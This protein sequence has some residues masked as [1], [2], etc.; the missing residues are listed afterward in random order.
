MSFRKNLFKNIIVLGG[1][2][3]TTQIISF[4]ATIVLSRLL[5][6]EEYGF[7]ALITVFTGFVKT[8]SDA[9]LS[10]LVIRSDYGKLFQRVL[11]YLSFIVGLILF[12]LVVLLAY[13][14]SLFYKD[15]ALILP[16]IIMSLNFILRSLTTVPFGVLSKEL[17]FN[18]L[19]S[20]ELI[21]ATIEVLFMI[22]LAYLGFSYWA[23]IIPSVIGSIARI[24]MYYA[25][26]GLKLK[27]YSRKYLVVGFRK[28]KS[29]IG[30]LS[31]FTFFN[32]WARNSDNL[33]IGKVYGA[34]SLGIYNRAYRLL[35]MVTSI[36][37]GLFGK[38]L[39][40][41]LKDLMSKGGDV[42][43]EYM[44]LLGIISLINFPIAIALI[45]FSNPLVILLWSDR[46]IL[47]AE[48]LPYIGVLI[49]TQTLNSTTGNVF[50][51]YGKE[52][53]LFRLGIP[54]N[55]ILIS[56]IA[57]GAFFSYVHVL[58]FYSLA[59]VAVNLPLVMFYGFK[60]SFGFEIKEIMSFWIPKILLSLFMIVSIWTEQLWLTILFTIIY[61]LHLIIRQRE[62]IAN[63]FRF[64]AR[65]LKII[66]D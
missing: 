51:L 7:V 22:I 23:L 9:G 24:F 12:G 40:P 63:G 57:T 62:D 65:K 43:K 1:Y 31:G 19:G 59:F 3:Y 29:I 54:V 4:L 27:I 46:W 52:K 47:V 64:I 8:F 6:P 58:R 11:H 21:G 26:T 48:L 56:A 45:F 55:I 39:Y 37:T 32:Y 20:L 30:N 18:S 14:I 66:K 44:N 38:V 61:L 35:T 33:I 60:Q 2:T 28:A 15:S 42:N 49:L 34:D 36:M 17:R 41:S 10:Y 25:K 50:I 53:T 5:L 16:T 13:P